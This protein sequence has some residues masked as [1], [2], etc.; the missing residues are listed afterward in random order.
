[1]NYRLDESLV[2]F[3]GK[4]YEAVESEEECKGCMFYQKCTR[5]ENNFWRFL[6][7]NRSE[8]EK[9]MCDMLLG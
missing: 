7:D 4:F 6:R 1:M 3:N 9:S 8:L 5:P 2:C